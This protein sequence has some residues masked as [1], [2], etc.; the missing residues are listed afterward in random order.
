M[1]NTRIAI[2]YHSSDGHTRKQAQAVKAGV[3]QVKSTE[4]LLLSVEEAQEHWD[5]LAA[6]EAII[7][8]TPTYVGG[9]SAAFKAFEEACV[10]FAASRMVD[11]RSGAKT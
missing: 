9:V 3:E 2:V 6:A 5:D 10:F 1:S 7:F 11:K 4:V 8:G